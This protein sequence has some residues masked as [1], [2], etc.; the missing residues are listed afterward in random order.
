MP[1]DERS[2]FILETERLLLRHQMASDIDFLTDLWSD[3]EVTRHMGGPRDKAWLR[4]VF[5]ES[6]ADPFQEEFD[7]WTAVE[8]SSGL[9][10]GHCGLLPKDVDGKDEIE[11][12]Y[13]LSPVAWGKGYAVEI[14]IAIQKHAFEKL[15]LHRLIA[16]IDPEN[17]GSE[18]VAARIGM[19]LEKETTREGSAIRRVYVIEAQD[20]GLV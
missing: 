6:A 18:R 16:L 11:L 2:L 20:L 4:S 7:L 1:H 13:I 8:K 12:N 10:I 17:E 14:G 3:P 9:P 15:G 5:E 19:H